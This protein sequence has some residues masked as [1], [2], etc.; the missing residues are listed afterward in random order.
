MDGDQKIGIVLCITGLHHLRRKTEVEKNQYL[1]RQI[2][3]MTIER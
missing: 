3:L 1:L 2:V